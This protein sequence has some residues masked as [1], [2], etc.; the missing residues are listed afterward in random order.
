MQQ[1]KLLIANRGE[2]AIRIAQ[3]AYD[4]GI[5]SVSIFSE[6]D[7]TSLHIQKTDES[8]PL[9]GSGP[10]AYLD[11]LQ[12]LAIAQ[13][14][15]C[16]LVH[17][18][19]GFL[20]ENA[21]FAE[22]CEKQGITF[23]GPR[24]EVLRMLGDKSQARKLA[25]EQGIPILPGTEQRSSL[26]EAEQFFQSLPEGASLLIKALSGGGG[27]GMGIVKNRAELASTFERCQMEAEKAF[28]ERG[29][30]CRA[31]PSL[32]SPCGGANHWGWQRSSP[33]M[34]TGV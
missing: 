27:K 21:A 32:G 3:A 34:G 33:S 15:D 7:A 18:G 29:P 30:L 13:E 23:I 6:D 16:T 12:I 22:V 28:G 2:I 17:P 10:R 1:A 24:P 19:Y 25:R 20:S 4:L 31:I 11:M 26:A 5:P 9:S 14:A 8:Y